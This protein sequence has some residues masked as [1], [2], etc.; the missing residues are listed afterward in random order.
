MLQEVEGSCRGTYYDYESSNGCIR[1][2]QKVD[3]V[4]TRLKFD[5]EILLLSE[6]YS[7]IVIRSGFNLSQVESRASLSLD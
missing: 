6:L 2:I 1:S 3:E 5:I 4:M 7:Y